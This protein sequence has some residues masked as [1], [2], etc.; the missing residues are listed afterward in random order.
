MF[1]AMECIRSIAFILYTLGNFEKNISHLQY[2]VQPIYVDN[3]PML[4][5]FLEIRMY[6]QHW[7][8]L[9]VLVIYERWAFFKDKECILSIMLNLSMLDSFLSWTN[10]KEMECIRDISLLQLCI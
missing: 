9:S 5:I 8:N 7:F 2:Y 1:S 6:L 10:F 4:D 3:L